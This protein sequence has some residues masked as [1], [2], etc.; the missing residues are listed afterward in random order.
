MIQVAAAMKRLSGDAKR[1]FGRPKQ[2]RPEVQGVY[3]HHDD[4]HIFLAHKINVANTLL[5]QSDILT[6]HK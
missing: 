3:F 1:R 2:T 6:W 5:A 4:K